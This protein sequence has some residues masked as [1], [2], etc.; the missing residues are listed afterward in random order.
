MKNGRVPPKNWREKNAFAPGILRFALRRG[1][2]ALYPESGSELTESQGLE[3]RYSK[4]V[5]LT[6]ASLFAS[7]PKPAAG[8]KYV[9]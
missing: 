7:T 8:C 6:S 9:L 4:Y 2:W 1:S 5:N 3:I